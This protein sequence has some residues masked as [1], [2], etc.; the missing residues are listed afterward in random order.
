MAASLLVFKSSST[1]GRSFSVLGRKRSV[2]RHPTTHKSAEKC[3]ANRY[4]RV[5]HPIENV[6]SR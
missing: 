6:S 5:N 3:G 1:G 4:R 2:P